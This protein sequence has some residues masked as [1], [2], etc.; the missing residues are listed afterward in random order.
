[1]STYYYM[2]SRKTKECIC[3]GR[4]INGENRKYTGPVIWVDAKRFYLP[5]W[6]LSL[7]MERFQSQHEDGDV[8][9][10]SEDD[11]YASGEYLGEDDVCILVGGDEDDSPPLQKYLP[12]LMNDEVRANIIKCGDLKIE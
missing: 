11:L 2:F 7:L 1:M 4:K 5:G 12:E 10:L 8:F 3:L 6:L 9:L